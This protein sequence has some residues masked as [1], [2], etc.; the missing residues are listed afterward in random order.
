MEAENRGLLKELTETRQERDPLKK[1]PRT[2]PGSR[3]PVHV[4]E[5]VATSI[6]GERDGPRL[7]RLAQ[8]VL[9]V[10]QGYTRDPR[11]AG[12]TAQGRDQGLMFSFAYGATPEL[13]PAPLS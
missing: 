11:T 7:R 10:A 9:P 6:P 2:S 13:M 3:Y 8:W 1:R 5:A 12:R 4:H